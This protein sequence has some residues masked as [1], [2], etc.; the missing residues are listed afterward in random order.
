MNNKEIKNTD[1][2]NNIQDKDKIQSNPFP[3]INKAQLE[4]KEDCNLVIQ[5]SDLVNLKSASKIYKH[6]ETSK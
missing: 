5:N 2:D 3:I 6:S 4:L 1:I